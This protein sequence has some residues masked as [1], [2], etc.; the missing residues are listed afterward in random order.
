[1]EAED[2]R[3]ETIP[4]RCVVYPGTHDND[5]VAGWFHCRSAA[6][7]RERAVVLR[8]L[9]TNGSEIHWDLI[10]VALA[11]AAD[12][13]VVAAQDLLGL[14]SEARMNRPGEARGNWSW[15][16]RAGELD[17]KVAARLRALTLTHG[18]GGTHAA[19]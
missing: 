5:T 2:S 17:G 6:A 10:R 12:V 16:L 15:R 11:S 18:R 13:A 8:Y 14:G 19:P 3:P 1:P 9:G 7:R 4:Q